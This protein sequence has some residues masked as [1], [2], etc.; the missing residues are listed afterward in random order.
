MNNQFILK[1]PT[2]NDLIARKRYIEQSPY[3]RFRDIELAEVN[4]QIA[5]QAQIELHNLSQLRKEQ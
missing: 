2:L 4:A 1:P 3:V 5:A